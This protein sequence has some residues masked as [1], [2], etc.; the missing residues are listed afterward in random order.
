MK[1]ILVNK[2]NITKK[3]QK[4]VLDAFIVQVFN[5]IN[6]N[7][8]KDPKESFIFGISGKWGEGKTRFLELLEIKLYDNGYLVVWINPWKFSSDKIAFL[9]YFLKIVGE[10]KNISKPRAIL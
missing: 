7:H 10:K 9:R 5:V 6:A 1:K 2:Q 4:N 3:T 8:N